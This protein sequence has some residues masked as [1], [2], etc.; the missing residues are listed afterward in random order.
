MFVAPFPHDDYIDAVAHHLTSLGHEPAQWWTET[1][2]GEQ[3]D[4][5][6]IFRGHAANLDLWTGKVWLGWDQRD[7]WAL[8]CH[9]ANN[10][11]RRVRN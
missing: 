11:D 9:N 5:V 3:L 6:I 7:G 2:D 10:A 4:G 1:P 8:C